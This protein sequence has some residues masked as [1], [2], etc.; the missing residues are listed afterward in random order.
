MALILGSAFLHAQTSLPASLSAEPGIHIR[1]FDGKKHHNAAYYEGLRQ[2]VLREFNIPFDS[3]AINLVF[4]GE[5]MREKMNVSNPDRFGTADWLGAFVP[6][7]L[8]LMVGDRESDDT[9]IH[10]YLHSLET[11]GLLFS[12]IPKPSVHALIQ[13]DEGLLLGSDSYLEFLK[14][15]R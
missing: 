13:Q 7:S 1:S 4:I 8:I 15:S 5:E 11:R 2:V 12:D 3:T 10:E 6:P 9:F 14:T